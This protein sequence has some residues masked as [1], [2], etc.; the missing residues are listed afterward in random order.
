MI[1]VKLVFREILEPLCRIMGSSF[2]GELSIIA[3]R[4]NS[5]TSWLHRSSGFLNSQWRA[6][7]SVYF[8]GSVSHD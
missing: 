1:W 5:P 4:L 8:G 7:D 2:A 6:L 3:A